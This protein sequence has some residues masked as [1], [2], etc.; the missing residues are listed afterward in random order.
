MN[1]NQLQKSLN[2]FTGTE[3]YF[4]HWS[5]LLYTDGVKFL[6]ETAQA[7]WLI[8][9]IASWQKKAIKDK[10]LRDFQF[11]S[12][13]TKQGSELKGANLICFRD[14]DDEAFR[15]KIEYTDFPMDE[16]KLYVENGV[17]MLPSER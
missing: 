15:Q 11:W 9:A 16:I 14:T 1:A 7:Y 10:M 13:Q 2:G 6:A 12:L 3:Q 17:L 5:G 4:R 8:D